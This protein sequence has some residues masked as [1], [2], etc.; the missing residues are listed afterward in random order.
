MVMKTILLG[1]IAVPGVLAAA[2]VAQTP[3]AGTKPALKVGDVREYKNTFTTV[4]C[5]RWEVKETNKNGFAV[6]QCAENLAYFSV[7]HDYALAKITGK[8]GD[9]LVEF[10]PYS[11]YLAFPLEP[12]K[13]WDGRYSGHTGDDGNSWTSEVSCEVKGVETLKL[14]AGDLPT[15][16]VDCTDS[17]SFFPMRGQSHSKSWYSPQLGVVVKNVNAEQAKW[18]FELT[19]YAPK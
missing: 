7:E 19:G 14:A 15:Y 3:P 12:G 13:K 11:P 8:G 10:K 5:A 6:L 2:A 4:K 9:T 16:R 17:W 18:D 1:V